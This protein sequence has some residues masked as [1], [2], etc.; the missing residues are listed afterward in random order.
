[1]KGSLP[2]LCERIGRIA[3]RSRWHVQS[4]RALGVYSRL[5]ASPVLAG[6]A[7]GVRV[8]AA[9]P[10]LRLVLHVQGADA[11]AG[12]FEDWQA[13]AEAGQGLQ[14]A[15]RVL[16]GEDAHARLAADVGRTAA[17][18]R[19][20][21]RAQLALQKITAPQDVAVAKLARSARKS[22]RRTERRHHQRARLMG[23]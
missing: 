4:Q 18:R 6:A 17:T 14:E 10:M 7:L 12:Q 11:P 9:T 15:L 8:A 2:W 1:M 23:L 22:A 13:A 5:A 3:R 16:L 21:R 19:Q 20:G